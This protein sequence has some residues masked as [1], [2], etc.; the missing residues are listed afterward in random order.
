MH[1][2]CFPVTSNSILISCH[3][4]DASDNERCGGRENQSLSLQRTRFLMFVLFCTMFGTELSK[5]SRLR[6]FTFE[7]TLN[8]VQEHATLIA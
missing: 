1:I 5:G 6:W 2:V 3:P 8:Y 7:R 4:N